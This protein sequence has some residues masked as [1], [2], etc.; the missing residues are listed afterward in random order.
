MELLLCWLICTTSICAQPLS[1]AKTVRDVENRLVYAASE[2]SDLDGY[3]M[4][5]FKT[6]SQQ[7]RDLLHKWEPS[8]FIMAGAGA[9]GDYYGFLCEFK[10]V[11][12]IF[13]LGF[14]KINLRT[15]EYK[16][17]NDWSEFLLIR[18]SDMTFDYSTG[19]LYALCFV[20]GESKLFTVN[21]SNG[22]YTKG[23]TIKSQ[24]VK[25][26]M[27]TLAATYDGRLYGVCSE[28]SAL[29]QIDKV[30]GFATY[31]FNLGKS[32]ALAQSMEFD[33]TDEALYWASGEYGGLGTGGP[34]SELYKIDINKKTIKSLGEFGEVPGNTMGLYI[35]FVLDGFDVPG[36]VT[37]LKVTPGTGGKEEA[38]I[39]WKNPVKTYGGDNLTGD[40]AVVLERDG[41]V[42]SS[43][44]GKSGAEMSWTDKNVKKGEHLYSVKT[45]NGIGEGARNDVNA[46]IGPDIPIA[47]SDLAINI[48]NECKSIKL[49]WTVP[50]KGAHDGFYDKSNVKFKV[51][52]YP[53]EEV[54][55]E[56]FTGT[57]FEDN[58]ITRLGAYY[59]GII[60]TNAA[61]ESKEYFTKNV[62]I[63][64]NPVPVPYTFDFQDRNETLNSWSIY[65]MNNDYVSWIINSGFG[66]S[67]FKDA[68]PAAEYV[69]IGTNLDADEW[70]ISPPLNFAAGKDYY[71][72]F[73]TRSSGVD[74]LTVAFGNLNAPESL[75]EIL[76]SGLFTKDA[77]TS[78]KFQNHLIQLPRVEGV[79]CIGINVVT[80][81]RESAI[82]QVSGFKVLEGTGIESA[83]SGEN[84]KV[85]L[86]NDR[87]EIEGDFRNADIFDAAGTRVATLN[88]ENPQTNTVN[89]GR[90]V[91]IVKITGF[92][93]VDTQ[94]VM[95]K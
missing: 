24:T 75:T 23:P 47:V 80:A 51:V 92:N 19:T 62:I 45:S 40:I 46:Y 29:Y 13:P 68:M 79:R 67:V 94:K 65:D 30:T 57:S 14:Y 15:G 93:S 2:H 17:L 87:L 1:K 42:I 12:G 63:A 18:V 43:S 6:G 55:K 82:L 52:R 78:N 41:E 54:I 85:Y 38:L 58:K 49:A 71:L 27:S 3:G 35:P 22:E 95:I 56:D 33:H 10:A 91:Y 9:N 25:R 31:Q 7:K 11:E 16:K 89:W 26:L 69:L 5:S 37:D 60:A 4:I 21:L 73:D 64:G 8:Q 66:M 76:K 34:A 81:Y 53:D 39:T 90:G 59:Y 28:D 36:L 44:T 61:G 83:F 72:S 20:D 50:Q 84:V 48:G 86:H 74:E 70:L 32:V 77:S 88:S